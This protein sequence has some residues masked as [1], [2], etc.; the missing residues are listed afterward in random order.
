MGRS[1]RRR[2]HRDPRICLAL[3]GDP[4]PS[5]A[6][7]DPRCLVEPATPTSRWSLGARYH[8]VARVSPELDF[9]MP[10]ISSSAGLNV[11]A[12]DPARARCFEV[13]HF[14]TVKRAPEFG[15]MTSRSNLALNDEWQLPEAYPTRTAEY[16]KARRDN[17][18]NFFLQDPKTKDDAKQRE[19]LSK[20][21]FENRELKDGSS[22]VLNN[23]LGFDTWTAYQ[24]VTPPADRKEWWRIPTRGPWQEI[25]LD[26]QFTLK[27]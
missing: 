17:F 23:T 2:P 20:P 24:V 22:F 18:V 1:P 27:P 15:T 9:V 12:A 3:I 26:T 14:K 16:S 19:Y 10:N 21:L 11:M 6:G 13:S 8:S 5:P 7:K 4:G 25:A